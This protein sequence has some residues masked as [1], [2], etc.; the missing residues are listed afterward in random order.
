MK[1]QAIFDSITP[2][3]IKD[4]PLIADAIEIFIKN[5]EENSS[6]SI[7]IKKIFDKDNELIREN[8]LK[9]Y[10][11]SLYDVITDVQQNEDLTS[12]FTET[13]GTVLKKNVTEI[14]NNEYF[15]TNRKY[16]Q[17]I[18]TKSGVNYTYLLAKY[19][20]TNE[21][22]ESDFKLTEIKPFHFATEGSIHRELY[23]NVVKPL[24]HPIGFTSIYTRAIKSS[25]VDYFGIERFYDVHK[26]EVRCLD[27]AYDVF[28]PDFDDTNVKTDFLTRVNILTDD[29]F[30]EA[31]YDTQVTVYT[32]KIIDVFT[33]DFVNEQTHRSILFTDG[34]FLEQFTNP[35][36]VYYRYYVDQLSNTSNYIRNYDTHCSLYLDYTERSEITYTD[37]ID[38]IAELFD[39]TSPDD[40]Y[41]VDAN[42]TD[43]VSETEIADAGGYYLHSAG[44][45]S[46][47][48]Y[49]NM[50]DYIPEEVGDVVL[51]VPHSL[52]VQYTGSASSTGT[53]G[54]YYIYEGI[55]GDIDF[56]NTDF[57]NGALWTSFST[58]PKNEWYL[59]M[60][61]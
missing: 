55:S 7:D 31:E 39:I 27:G 6:V 51:T 30:T 58:T 35:I 8:L 44:D 41:D 16:K 17:N 52:Q 59:R 21:Y 43:T 38:E 20:Q 25:L 26:I 22:T 28:T 37:T 15:T 36:N 34:T 18:G 2:E 12:K 11:S 45:P 29:I 50:L 49:L 40:N 3:N 10:L 33:A 13:E 42:T 54:H 23:E 56:S 24:S 47:N 46:D 1:L 9:I 19:F 4:I 48:Y 5:L 53:N 57:G 32:S 61:S 14:L 60:S